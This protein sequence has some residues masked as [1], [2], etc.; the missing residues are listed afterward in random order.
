MP[1][2]TREELRQQLRRNVIAP[3]YVLYGPETF[4]RDAA[5]R[6]ITDRCFAEGDLRDFNLDEFSLNGKD[7]IGPAMAAASQL[8]M[9]SQRRV[10][11]IVDA[12]VTSSSNRDTLREEYEDVLAPYL[13]TPAESTVLIIVADELNGNRKIT[14][15]L[16]RYAV[17]VQFSPLDDHELIQWVKRRF[18]DSDCPVDDR[19][20]RHLID[21][22]GSDLRRLSNETDKLVTASL[23]MKLITADLI[24]Q[25]AASTSELENFAL[26]KSIVSG[27]GRN[28][29][30]VMKKILADGGEPIALLGAIA[31]SFRRLLMAKEMMTR[32]DDRRQVA[33]Q[34]RMPFHE[35][36]MFFAAARRADRDALLKVFDRLQQTDVAMKTSL[37][38]SDQGQMQLEVLVCDLIEALRHP[39]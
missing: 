19:T 30:A 10:V 22:V 15:L 35:Q 20:A 24:D 7:S 31:Y 21:I 23:P 2:L 3:V 38:G 12:R 9:M 8:P 36:E 5:A 26:S 4:L 39:A 25:L 32:G 11:R 29:L 1:D 17:T 28:A 6:F 27:N 34:L 14:K 33:G 37:G 13:A 16:K 18:A